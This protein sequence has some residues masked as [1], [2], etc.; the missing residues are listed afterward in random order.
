[1][2][3]SQHPFEKRGPSLSTTYLGTTAS[4]AAPGIVARD[5]PHGRVDPFLLA[6]IDEAPTIAPLPSLPTMIASDGGNGIVTMAVFQ[7]PAQGRKRWGVHDMAAMWDACSVRIV[8]GGLSSAE[9]LEAISRI[10][11]LIDQETQG[12][13]HSRRDATES[14]TIRQIPAVSPA[15]LRSL[16]HGHAILLHRHLPPVEIEAIPRWNDRNL[17]KWGV[18]YSRVSQP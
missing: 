12:R 10:C 14:V 9:D 17:R 18:R 13:T 16:P 11:G 1:M 6:A 4:H 5:F 15:Q 2:D 7:S 8:F 3:V